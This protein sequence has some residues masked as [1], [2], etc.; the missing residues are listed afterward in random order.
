MDMQPLDHDQLIAIVDKMPAFPRSVQQVLQLSSNINVSAKEIVHVIECDPVLTVKILKVINSA[1]YGLSEKINSVQRAV[2][3]IGLNTIKNLA[4]SV[5]ALGVLKTLNKAGFDA[6]EFL[7]HSLTTAAVSRRLGERLMRSQLECSDCFVAGLLHDFGKVIFAQF[8]PE[9][10]KSCLQQS[11]MRGIPLHHAELECIGLH[12][13][14]AGQILA[15]KWGFSEMLAHAIG[16]HHDYPETI[17][18]DC[19]YTANQITKLLKFGNSG[20]PEIDPFP[21]VIT[22]RFG[23]PLSALID[24]L[25]GLDAIKIESSALI[26]PI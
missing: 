14:Q 17:Y 22:N 12:H 9:Q 21:E 6:N 20:N 16:S 15:R 2:V 23:L 18:A 19:I 11:K 1:I 26:K 7:L 3:L 5:A 13:A 8:M 25:P 4:L 10:F 24:D